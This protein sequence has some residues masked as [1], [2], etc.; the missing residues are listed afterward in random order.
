M[1]GR[2]VFLDRDGV[3]NSAIIRDGKPYPPAGLAELQIPAGTREALLRLKGAGYALIVVSNQPDVA[4]GQTSRETVEAINSRLAA[5]LPI[6]EFRTCF[7][8]GDGCCDCRKP[9]PGMLL[10]A[11]QSHGID[12]ARSF[13]IG[14]RWRDIDAGVAAGCKTIFLDADYSERRPAKFDYAVASLPQAVDVILGTEGSTRMEAIERLRVKVFADGADK[15]G[16]LEMYAK[17]FIKGLTTNPTL[18]RKAGVNDYRAFAK[19][20]L[21]EIPDRP[22]S[23]EVFS[24]DF[25]DMERQAIEIAGWGENVYVKIP[26][27]NTKRLPSYELVRALARRRVKLNVTA[28]MTLG[29]VR[30]VAAALSPA[31]PSYVSVF[32]GRIADTGRD[33][34]PLMAAA[35]ELLKVNPSSELIWASP[36][37]LLNIFQADAIGCHVI[38]VTNDILKKLSLVGYD[39]DEYSLDTVKMFHGDAAAAGFRL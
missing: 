4:R 13:M 39:L 10:A 37:E 21:A 12:L 6:D 3:V 8:D 16:M 30:D 14:D 7:H 19:E 25:A 28:L 24:D 38:T 27:T 20:V 22:I 23:F 5:T 9:K 31:V 2:A 15:R 35:V 36:R 1:S 33:P 34:V 26:V 29:Q 17:P 32:A 18:M 11:A